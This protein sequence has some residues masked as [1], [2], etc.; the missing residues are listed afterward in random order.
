ML[1]PLLPLF[2]KGWNWKTALTLKMNFCCKTSSQTRVLW[3]VM[4]TDCNT[5]WHVLTYMYIHIQCVC[6][7]CYKTICVFL[8]YY[9]CW[10]IRYS[11]ISEVI[12]TVL[13]CT[14]IINIQRKMHD[15]FMSHSGDEKYALYTWK[16]DI[17]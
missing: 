9:I 11:M 13:Y 6:S 10:Y 4:G 17:L 7:H 2:H 12:F 3:S 15:I 8:M 5:A 16:C 1:S 14:Y